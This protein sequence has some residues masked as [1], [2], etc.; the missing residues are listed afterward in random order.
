MS[1]SR[2]KAVTCS[3]TPLENTA[4]S[5]ASID[6]TVFAM[7]NGYLA[8]APMGTVSLTVFPAVF[9]SRFQLPASGRRR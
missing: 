2:H 6:T 3:G 5:F 8:T 4:K 1:S 7:P 9:I